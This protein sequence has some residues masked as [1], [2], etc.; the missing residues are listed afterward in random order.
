MYFPNLSHGSNIRVVRNTGTNT[1][2][3]NIEKSGYDDTSIVQLY[4]DREWAKEHGLELLVDI[5]KEEIST[6]D[7]DDGLQRHTIS[8]EDLKKR[9]FKAIDGMHRKT[10]MDMLSKRYLERGGDPEAN[11]YEWGKVSV[12]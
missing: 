12:V 6:G 5:Y 10:A 1:L 9:K 8:R 4:E 11:P 7:D 3:Q 2:I